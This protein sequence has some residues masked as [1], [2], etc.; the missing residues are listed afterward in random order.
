MIHFT[1]TI[2]HG[3]YRNFREQ[4][5][6]TFREFIAG[7]PYNASVADSD[8]KMAKIWAEL[9]LTG[10]A[11]WGWADYTMTPP[12]SLLSRS[13]PYGAQLR[14]SGPST[15]QPGVS[16]DPCG[17]GTPDDADVNVHD[18]PGRGQLNRVEI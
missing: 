2:H 10:R 15:R 9:S 14:D 16:I 4:D 17:F 8:V 11:E 13:L 3:N 5:C 1:E 12:S 7:S 18:G 6:A